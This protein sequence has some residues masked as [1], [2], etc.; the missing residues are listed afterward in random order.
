MAATTMTTE[1]RYLGESRDSRTNRWR[2]T[3]PVCSH[4][5]EPE[6]TMRSTQHVICP[7]RKCGR[8]LVADYNAEPP[9][10]RALEG[11]ETP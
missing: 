7:G 4:A 10:V 11:E 3:C 9:V 1:P 6:T 2:I 5:F 8:E